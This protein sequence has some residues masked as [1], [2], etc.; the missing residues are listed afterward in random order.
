MC[1]RRDAEKV[2]KIARDA[3]PEAAAEEERPSRRDSMAKR[4]ERTAAHSGPDSD[5]D[6]SDD[7]VEQALE[8]VEEMSAEQRQRFF[9]ALGSRYAY[10]N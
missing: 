10:Q 3:D 7:P 4:R 6:L 1:T 8:L 2:M 5:A 9:A